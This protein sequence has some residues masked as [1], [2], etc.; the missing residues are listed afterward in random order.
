MPVIPSGNI[1]ALTLMVAQRAAGLI[2]EDAQGG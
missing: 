1:N 2:L